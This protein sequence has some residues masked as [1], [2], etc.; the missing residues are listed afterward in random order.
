MLY[1]LLT[2]SDFLREGVSR[3]LTMLFSLPRV[4]QFISIVFIQQLLSNFTNERSG[5]FYKSCNSKLSY[6]AFS[7]TI[8]ACLSFQ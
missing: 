4:G 7:R 5:D 6:F 1:N 3:A 8:I 2:N